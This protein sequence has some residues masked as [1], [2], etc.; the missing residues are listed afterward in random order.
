MQKQNI[1]EAVDFL[2]G[3]LQEIVEEKCPMSKL[4]I[5]KSLRS[6]Y[7][8]PAQIAHKVLADRLTARDPGNKPNSGDRIPYVYIVAKD[9]K[10]QG[11]KIET[12]QFVQ[13]NRLK[14]DY[15]FYITNQ[16]MKPLQQLFSLV[17][18]DIWILMK[19]PAKLKLFLKKSERIRDDHKQLEKMRN[20]EV[21]ILLFDP[22]LKEASN[23]RESNQ[24]INKFFSSASCSKHV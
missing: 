2:R 11:D 7:K 3:A 21:K 20:E 5:S 14:I 18:E 4:I 1:L 19:K 12:P 23:K 22:F 13:E 10:L 9:A 6:D 16:I 17:I 24:S 8:N 15:G